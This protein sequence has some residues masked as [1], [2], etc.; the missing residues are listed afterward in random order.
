VKVLD[1]TAHNPDPTARDLHLFL[2]LK[3]NL[4]D[5][6]IHEDEKMKNEVSTSLYVQ[7][8]ELCD[9]G[10]HNLVPRLNKF[11]DKGGD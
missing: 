6:K 2:R 5:Q 1:E 8:E 7:V 9:I 4:T 10:I 11:L 3:E